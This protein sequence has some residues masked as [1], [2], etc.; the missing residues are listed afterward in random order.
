MEEVPVSH[1]LYRTQKILFW[2]ALYISKIHC[3][4]LGI[5]VSPPP[6]P[7][8]TDVQY[9]GMGCQTGFDSE[10][11]NGYPFWPLAIGLGVILIP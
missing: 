3:H 10:L 1:T 11:S 9:M 5:S 6:P 4:H 7:P 2:N 8:L